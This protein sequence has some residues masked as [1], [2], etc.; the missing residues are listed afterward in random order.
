MQ[1]PRLSAVL[2]RRKETKE[3]T[4]L[5]TGALDDTPSV[6]TKPEACANSHHEMI[7]GEVPP[8]TQVLSVYELLEL[9][10]LELPERD[11]LLAQRVCSSFKS[12]IEKSEPIQQRLFFRPQLQ[13]PG[14]QV[15]RI[16]DLLLESRIF[17]ERLIMAIP[18]ANILHVLLD[19]SAATKP[20]HLFLKAKEVVRTARSDSTHPWADYHI[21]L[22]FRIGRYC[23]TWPFTKSCKVCNSPPL[24]DGSW[25]RMFMSQPPVSIFAANGEGHRTWKNLNQFAP[26]E[27]V[28]IWLNGGDEGYQGHLSALTKTKSSTEREVERRR[29]KQDAVVLMPGSG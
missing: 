14:E 28:G 22:N 23:S 9:I 3:T 16:N 12:V 26:T 11:L 7:D 15:P 4:E 25:Q 1:L 2:S 27:K 24:R 8:S 18:G 19:P 17:R 5:D 29:Q 21:Q 10:L 6:V 13:S 20:T